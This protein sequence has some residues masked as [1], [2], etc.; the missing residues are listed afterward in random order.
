MVDSVPK[1]VFRKQ[2]LA[3]RRNL[4]RDNWLKNSRRAQ[5][6]VI[7]L[8]EFVR[9]R[10]V[11]FYS[12]IAREVDTSAIFRAAVSLGKKTLYPL[13]RGDEMVLCEVDDLKQ[14]ATG[15][16]GILEPRAANKDYLA[17]EP[18]FIVIPGVAFDFC[19]RRI[20]Y[21]KGYYD[22]FLLHLELQALLVGLC[23]DFQLIDGEL[24]T[25]QYDMG[26]DVVVT[27]QRVIRCLSNRICLGDPDS[28]RGG[29][30]NAE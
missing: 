25:D 8:P 19:G 16:M 18:D 10:C 20:G 7:A 14:L 5:D 29:C 15:Y 1:N 21:G 24:P 30:G 22:R 4:S 12:A 27:E 11:A 17:N 6:N 23:H 28:Y 3:Q 26:M 13:V 9:A 2:K